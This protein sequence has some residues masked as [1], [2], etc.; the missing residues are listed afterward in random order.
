MDD[1]KDAE[2][3]S[4]MRKGITEALGIIGEIGDGLLGCSDLLRVEQTDKVFIDLSEW[5]KNLG[6]LMDFI[7]ELKRGVG[8]LKGVGTSTEPLLC[9]D[10]SFNVF[11]EMLSA[12]ENKD[13]I[14]LADLIQYEL[15][16]L[17]VEGEKGLSELKDT[18][19]VR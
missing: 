9:W 19:T 6:C 11:E 8:Y 14:T 10:R 17:L 15:H 18:I 3:L 16:P 4:A 1:A 2:L 13:W 7:K 5:I 12:F